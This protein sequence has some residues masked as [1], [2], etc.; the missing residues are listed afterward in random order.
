MM[1]TA[2]KRS[3]P[4]LVLRCPN[5]KKSKFAAD[6]RAPVIERNRNAFG[7]A[8]RDLR[9]TELW[10]PIV[11]I[12]SDADP[13]GPRVRSNDWVVTFYCATGAQLYDSELP[14]QAT[15]ER[16]YV[17]PHPSVMRTV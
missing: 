13:R 14:T 2:G 1:F 6:G 15:A 11:I 12:N 10:Q 16:R 3:L 8:A 5:C 17:L 4:M 7:W 9:A